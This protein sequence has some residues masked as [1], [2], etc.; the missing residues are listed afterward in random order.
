MHTLNA[1]EN[2][3]WTRPFLVNSLP[4]AGTHLV[5]KAV[6]LFPGIRWEGLHIGRSHRDRFRSAEGAE[7]G[8]ATVPIGVDWPQLVSRR[9]VHEALRRLK[10]GQFATAHLPHSAE[11]GGLL[12][13]LRIKSVL[14]LR[15]PRDV[16][17]SHANHI[18][19][20]PHHFMFAHYST[21]S[22]ADQILASI[23]GVEPADHAAPRMLNVCE[24]Y[25]SVLQWQREP[26]NYTTH[27]EKLVGPQAGG[28][29]E[30]QIEELENIVRHLEI[31]HDPGDLP[32]IAAGVYGGTSTFRKGLKGQ[33]GDWRQH[34]IA[35]HRS[36][37]KHVAGSLLIELGYERDLD[38]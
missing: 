4:K 27:F 25:Q 15:D 34:L 7:A 23:A 21:L 26:D 36:A 37:L 10:T 30:A 18:S 13:T 22:S 28:A 8:Q 9:V 31:R 12:T 1:A 33:I 14:I 16:V 35:E 5:A 11:M 17:V 24:R 2:R 6:S 20:S 32:R 29:Q 19:R 38:W 3:L